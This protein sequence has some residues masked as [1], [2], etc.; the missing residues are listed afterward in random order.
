MPIR[1]GPKNP[2]RIYLRQWREYH[3]LTQQQ[4]ADRIGCSKATISQWESGGRSPSVEA[5]AEALGEPADK[6]HGPAPTPE[7]QPP[8]ERLPGLPG[9]LQSIVA[10]AVA[11]VLRRRMKR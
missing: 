9:D 1:I 11:E 5:Y 7:P 4:V 10:E 3:H 2:R 8:K 6:L